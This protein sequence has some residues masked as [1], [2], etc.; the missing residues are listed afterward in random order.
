MYF[1]II[2]I[3]TLTTTY[4]KITF[5]SLIEKEIIKD[6]LH[7]KKS[8]AEIT[9]ITKVGGGKTSGS[10]V[11][12]GIAYK[13]KQ[14]TER[15]TYNIVKIPKLLI[16][17]TNKN[18]GDRVDI[19]YNENIEWSNRTNAIYLPSEN[20]LLIE[21]KIKGIRIIIL[22]LFLFLIYKKTLRNAI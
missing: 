9:N 1:L 16:I 10:Y 13:H 7:W 3:N 22:L 14:K 4:E 12:L 6:S 19:I 18:V 15:N 17:G 8:R 21:K 5:S 20:D 2:D 11:V